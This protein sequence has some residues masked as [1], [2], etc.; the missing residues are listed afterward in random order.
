MCSLVKLARKRRKATDRALQE[1]VRDLRRLAGVCSTQ[2]HKSRGVGGK[3]EVQATLGSL[4]LNREV[5]D[6]LEPRPTAYIEDEHFVPSSYF[7]RRM[8]KEHFGMKSMAKSQKLAALGRMRFHSNA[9][10]WQIMKLF[11]SV[12]TYSVRV[13]SEI[14]PRVASLVVEPRHR[15]G[16]SRFSNVFF[17]G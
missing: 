17:N 15:R 9:E 16:S 10:R 1:E 11:F 12:T 14:S 5:R 13:R 4:D 2:S 6:G 3:V 7:A 8:F